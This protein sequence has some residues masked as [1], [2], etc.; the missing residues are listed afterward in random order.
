MANSIVVSILVPVYNYDVAPLLCRLHEQCLAIAEDPEIEIVAVDDGST[1]K[2]DN[3]PAAEKLELVAYHELDENRGRAAVRNYLLRLARG[4]YVLFLDADMMPDDSDF[5]RTYFDLAQSDAEIVCGGIS[6]RQYETPDPAASFYLYKSRKTEA[7]PAA[8][9]NK[10]P[11]RYFFPS[12]LLIRRDI[13]KNVKFDER[14]EGYGYEDIDWGI[15]LAKSYRIQH[16]DNTCTHF[17]VMH[18]DQVFRKMRESMENY[19]LLCFLHPGETKGVGA[20]RF[21]GVMH[22]FPDALLSA[23]DYLL[24]RIYALVTRN[25]LLFFIFQ[26][27]KVV[28]LARQLKKKQKVRTG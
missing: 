12:N 24:G 26:A 8:A 13:M 28:L 21:A 9:R 17:G 22:Y 15:R 6:Y 10:A 5:V 27:D 25:R 3:R 18:K 11:W 14:F 2:F 16:I 19:A 20:V 1:V 23:A 7:L 4:R